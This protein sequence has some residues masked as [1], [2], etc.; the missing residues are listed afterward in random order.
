MP[1]VYSSPPRY[2]V[3]NGKRY[4][5]VETDNHHG[6]AAATAKRLRREGYKAR[7]ISFRAKIYG[8]RYVGDKFAIY[9]RRG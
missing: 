1:R 3:F 4:T 7:V 6:F 8:G 9:S 2:K 5:L